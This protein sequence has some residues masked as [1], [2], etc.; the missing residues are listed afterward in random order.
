MF[1]PRTSNK[2]E[3]SFDLQEL[4]ISIFLI[5]TQRKPKQ[6][7]LREKGLEPLAK[8]IMSQKIG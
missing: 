8:I 2:I 7:L 6:M 3:Q 4:K 1:S 5:K